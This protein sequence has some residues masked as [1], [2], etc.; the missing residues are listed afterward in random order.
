MQAVNVLSSFSAE[1]CALETETRETCIPR[2]WDAGERGEEG[3]LDDLSSRGESQASQVT[4][5]NCPTY[6]PGYRYRRPPA[7]ELQARS[8]GEEV[9]RA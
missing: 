1:K 8:F 9:L 5:M 6:I 3:F 7:Q 2:T 4:C